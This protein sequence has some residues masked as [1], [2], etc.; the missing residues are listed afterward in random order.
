MAKKKL[1]R[2]KFQN[3]K[4]LTHMEYIKK[5]ETINILFLSRGEPINQ[6][7]NLKIKIHSIFSRSMR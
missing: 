4:I 2:S 7:Q 5:V 1:K 3:L 6:Y